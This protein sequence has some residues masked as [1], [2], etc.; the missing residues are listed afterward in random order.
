M[1][2]RRDFL[3]NA[4]VWPGATMA[5]IGGFAGAPP[6]PNPAPAGADPRL[7]VTD[8]GAAG[9]GRVDDSAAIQATIDALDGRRGIVFFPPG[10][11]RCEAGINARRAHLMGSGVPGISGGGGSTIR[12]A[13]AH[14]IRSSM[15]DN[16]GYEIGFLRIRGSAEREA[17]GQVLVDFTGQNYPRMRECRIARAEVGIRL[18]NGN[19]VECHYGAFFNVHLD[20]CHI[21]LDVPGGAHSHKFFAGRLW[22]CRYGARNVAASDI[23]F[24]GTHFESDTPLWHPPGDERPITTLVATRQESRSA[25]VIESGSLSDLGSYWSGYRRA[26]AFD[27]REGEIVAPGEITTAGIIGDEHPATVNLLRNPGLVPD[28]ERRSIP[29]WRFSGGEPRF[30]TGPLGRIVVF[31]R[32]GDDSHFLEQTGIRL[33]AGRYRVGYGVRTEG[34]AG[35]H[36]YVHDGD[37][38]LLDSTDL[39]AGYDG[40]IAQRTFTLAADSDAIRIRLYRSRTRGNTLCYFAPFIVPAGAGTPYLPVTESA[41]PFRER[42]GT[43]PPSSGT[44]KAGDRIHNLAPQP[45]GYAGWICTSDGAPGVWHGFGRIADGG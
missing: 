10:D 28:V 13:G 12:F 20:Q 25:P 26:A 17:N 22:D 37:R 36:I 18:D 35:I 21:G 16:F 3:R 38:R 34:S 9:D 41:R 4:A 32:V 44:W 43:A 15:E 19:S 14:G 8:F 24:I 31:D 27:V 11:Y 23:A 45:S 42:Y 30:T 7:N 29:G 1:S 39:P 6:E 33:S 40:G 5:G 2:S